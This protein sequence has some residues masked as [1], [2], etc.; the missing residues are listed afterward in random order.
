[1]T[2][3]AFIAAISPAAQTSAAITNVPAGFVVADA[4]LESGW[5]SS[6]LTQNAMNLF[7]VKADSSWA[8]PTYAIPTR[9]FLNGQWV[10][11]QALFRKY[12]DWLGS[13]Q[14][15]AAFLINNPRY[16]PAFQTSDS[17]SFAKAVAAA[18][19]ATD[20]QYAQKIIEIINAHNL[21]TLDAPANP[22]V[23]V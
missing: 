3:Q 9:E 2:P 8:G 16:A 12:S 17:A 13:I 4:A 7:G 23:N 20:P 6:G 22:V 21:T 15:H 19:Y 18:G 10:M 14:D 1:M 5:G 11:V